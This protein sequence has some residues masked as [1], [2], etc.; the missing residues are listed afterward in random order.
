MSRFTLF[1][2]FII[3]SLQC[4]N[5]IASKKHSMRLLDFRTCDSPT[6][7]FGYLA[8]NI[9][10]LNLSIY[11]IKGKTYVR[12]NVTVKED[13]SGPYFWRLCVQ[14]ADDSK[15]LI[16]LMEMPKMTC[17]DLLVRLLLKFTNVKYIPKSCTYK[18]GVYEFKGFDISKVDN[19]MT[20]IPVRPLGKKRLLISARSDRETMFCIDALISVELIDY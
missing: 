15:R 10:N 2:V 13:L 9:F 6:P 17:R 3:F 18:K 8:S 14:E 19:Q 1:I 16:K 11:N 20:I 4:L 12:G 5:A 7:P